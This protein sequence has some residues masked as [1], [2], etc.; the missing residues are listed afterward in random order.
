MN[1]QFL[2]SL[3]GVTVSC[4]MMGNDKRTPQTH[5]LSLWPGFLFYHSSYQMYSVTAKCW[6]L[7]VSKQHKQDVSVRQSKR[8]GV[9]RCC[10]QAV[11]NVD[12]TTVSV[13]TLHFHVAS[14]LTLPVPA[15]SSAPLCYK[16]GCCSQVH[17]SECFF[18][19]FTDTQ[20]D[21]IS[22][23][24]MNVYHSTFLIFDSFTHL[25]HECSSVWKTSKTFWFHLFS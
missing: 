19:L 13:V 21:Y 14:I 1:L 22:D 6:L 16:Q 8:K 12:T 17:V 7:L 4:P 23:K 25:A 10:K 24:C 5:C 2:G 15:V 11:V 9:Q 3:F 18:L 20:L